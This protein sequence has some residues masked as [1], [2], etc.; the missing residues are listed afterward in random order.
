MRV[1]DGL[2][3][4]EATSDKLRQRL[5]EMAK[6]VGGED[7]V[8]LYLAGHGKVSPGQEMFYFIPSDG[9]DIIGDGGE[10]R[11]TAVS[12]AMLAEALRNLPARRVVLIIDACQSGGAIEALSK[13]ATV[14]AQIEQRRAQLEP[15]VAGHEH[16]VGV[17]LIAA[18]MPLSY[19]IGLKEGESV[20]AETLL[21]ALQQRESGLLT[22]EQLATYVNDHLPTNSERAMQVFA[23]SHLSSHSV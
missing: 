3:N 11:T 18:T 7:V 4:G 21:N 9:K 1:W 14:K 19:A 15:K 17:H 5:A 13:V 23:K 22:L 8:L 10:L 12:T 20:L 6:Q 2:Y 16:G